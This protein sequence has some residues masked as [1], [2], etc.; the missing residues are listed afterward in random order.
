MASKA[1]LRRSFPG[2]AIL[3]PAE[4]FHN[5]KFS[6]ELASFLQRLDSEQVD[7]VMA[8]S[9]KGKSVVI[10]ERDSPHPRLVTELLIALLAPYGK[11]IQVRSIEKRIR[12]E[13]CWSNAFLPWRRS[14]T[15]LTLKVVIQLVLV[16]S[17][18]GEAR[19]QYKN[20]MLFLMKELS[21]LGR[22]HKLRPDLLFTIN[23]KVARRASKLASGLFD[24][25]G[26][27]ALHAVQLTRAHI[28]SQ[29]LPIQ[30]ADSLKLKPVK[31][32]LSDIALSLTTSRPY[33]TSALERRL[34]PVAG[35]NFSASASPRLSCSN[36]R[37][38]SLEPLMLSE[39]NSGLMLADFE[40]WVRDHLKVWLSGLK[41]N[42][43]QSREWVE[44]LE[45]MHQLHTSKDCQF[46]KNLIHTYKTAATQRYNEHPEHL[47]LMLLTILEL[48]CALDIIVTGLFPLLKQ[49]TPEIPTAILQALL[50]PRNEQ[51]VRLHH[52][53][54]YLKKRHQKSSG[55]FP[56][57]FGMISNKSISVQY[58]DNCEA[59]QNL[60][61]RIERDADTAR[62]AKK[63]ELE[64]KT[65]SYRSIKERANSLQ[66][67]RKINRRG[68]EYHAQELCSK[69][70]LENQAKGIYIFVHEWP[71]SIS[72]DQA[73]ATV[74]ELQCPE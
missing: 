61:R 26:K 66:H 20:F 28:D 46:L 50:L 53:E 44:D 64:Q 1:S 49:Y 60:R 56:S 16:N 13:V 19:F 12:D 8:K 25:V 39:Q 11:L 34:N 40:A 21:T 2:R 37:L 23:A 5:P 59:L 3:F 74:F 70:K 35:E 48:W 52:I 69:C 7:E 57:V 58:Y 32:S 31:P 68:Q 55:S 72:E 41:C 45:N 51:L 27:S 71:L 24:F 14:P 54:K 6:D 29:I 10:E 17:G 9:R 30:R 42:S 15:W 67:L 4:I 63:R 18:L 33:L 65:A 62:E 73:K 36:A 47:S 22:L 43:V 38:P